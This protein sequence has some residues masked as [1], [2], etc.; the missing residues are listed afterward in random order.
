[1]LLAFSSHIHYDIVEVI[2]LEVK[3]VR[4]YTIDDQYTTMPW[5]EIDNVVFDVG[6]VLLTFSPTGIL[7]EYVPER[8]DLHPVLMNK[9]FHSPYWAMMDRGTATIEE[10][11]ELM[12]QAA[13]ELEPY[14]RQVMENWVQMKEI[15]TE[16]V[17]ALKLCKARGKKVFVLS[18]YGTAFD[19]V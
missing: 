1:M 3:S 7:Q 15:I 17:D 9:V 13:P 14:I 11:T 18:N 16:G 8:P 5:D 12:V 10:S 4:T 6:N 19:I 2:R